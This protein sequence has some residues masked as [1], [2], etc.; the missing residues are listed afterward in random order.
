MR[1]IAHF[2]ALCALIHAV[3]GRLYC[4]PPN[5]VLN[6]NRSYPGFKTAIISEIHG[7]VW[8]QTQQ[9]P[10]RWSEYLGGHQ[11][12]RNLYNHIG[13]L[14]IDK[15]YLTVFYNQTLYPTPPT[16]EVIYPPEQF[17]VVDWYRLGVLDWRPEIYGGPKETWAIDKNGNKTLDRAYWKT[18]RGY[19][20]IYKGK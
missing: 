14:G 15:I 2:F 6:S 13:I 11:I 18:Q 3:A 7:K 19:Q 5:L 20:P 8:I 10:L 1:E 17:C 4:P 9:H 16:I 12:A